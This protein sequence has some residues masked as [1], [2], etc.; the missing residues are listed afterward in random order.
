MTTLNTQRRKFTG[1]V[2]ACKMQ[3]TIV[4]V[5]ERLVWSKKYKKQY[6]QSSKFMVHDEKG[7]AQVG[8][9]VAIEECRPLSKL[10]R[11][12]LVSIVK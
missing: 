3:K 9:T 12:R 11:W 4:V 1:K 5:V 2:L 7:Q 8:Q 6:R 10:K